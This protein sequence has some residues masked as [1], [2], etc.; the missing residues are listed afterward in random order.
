MLRLRALRRPLR[1][2]FPARTSRGALTEHAAHYLVLDDP[3]HP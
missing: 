2:S 3:A 1:F